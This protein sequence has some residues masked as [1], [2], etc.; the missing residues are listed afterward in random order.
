VT[1]ECIPWDF[2]AKLAWPGRV[3]T[4]VGTLRGC[5]RAWSAL[6]EPDQS[7]CVIHCIAQ[8]RIADWHEGRTV[9][10]SVGI[11]QLVSRLELG[12]YHRGH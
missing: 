12:W 5:V 9:I 8:V 2:E 3:A 7:A 11:Q 10:S 6:G 1:D 4:E